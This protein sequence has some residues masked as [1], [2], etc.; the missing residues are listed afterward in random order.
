MM[1]KSSI[2]LIFRYLEFT[3]IQW[4]LSIYLSLSAQ[5]AVGTFFMKYPVAGER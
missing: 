3:L 4:R 1:F 2:Q 5:V